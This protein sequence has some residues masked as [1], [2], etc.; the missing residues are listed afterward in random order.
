M[1]KS[2]STNIIDRIEGLA[3]ASINHTDGENVF[4]VPELFDS[5]VR[6]HG[7]LLEHFIALPCPQ[8]DKNINNVR[9][10][11][12][13]H[14]CEDGMYYVCAG[15]F[16]GIMTNNPKNS[17]FQAE[18]MID[19]ATCWIIVPRFY[20]Q[21]G[22]KIYF[23]PYDKIYVADDQYK[24][25]LVPNFESMES[26]TTGVDRLRFPICEVT[27]VIDKNGQP[28]YQMGVDYAVTANGALQWLGQNR[29][30]FNPTLKEGGVY[31]IRYLY[32]PYWYVA[33]VEH[34][35]RLSRVLNP[36]TDDNTLVRLPQY[37]RCVRERYFRSKDNTDASE[38]VREAYTPSSGGNLPWR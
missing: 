14:N 28:S 24:E 13:D 22:K 9:S 17:H 25:V 26:S 32:R 38:D 10:N 23:S 34:E 37:L 27:H 12:A 21:G 36:E 18:G 3:G 6:S 19:S 1:A 20:E 16:L 4:F 31:S 7:V 35:I 30:Q 11:H 33:T 2:S 8:S 15:T 5:L 29:P